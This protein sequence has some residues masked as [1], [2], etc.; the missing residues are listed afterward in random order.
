MSQ[1]TG[2]PTLKDIETKGKAVLVRVD[3]NVPTNSA[4]EVLDSTRIEAAKDTILELRGQGAKII[5]I[6]HMGRPGGEVQEKFSLKHVLSAVEEV[7]GQPVAF[8]EHTVGDKAEAAVNQ[9]NPGQILLLENL[10]FDP[11]EKSND[12]AFAQRLA[13]LADLYV[14][15][16]FSAAHRAHASTAAVTHYLPAYAGR[17]MERE[18]K[19][20]TDALEDPERPALALVGGAKVSTKLDLL[21][22]IV[23][24][25]DY[26]VLGGG[27]ANTFLEAKGHTIGQSLSE[28]DMVDTV[29]E[30]MEEAG[31]QGCE[32]ILPEIVM[33]AKELKDNAAAAD[34]PLAEVADDDKILDLGAAACSEIE[35]VI[36]QCQTVLWN[37]PLGVFEVPPFDRAT[38]RIARYVAREVQNGSLKAIAGGGDTVSAL[39]QTGVAGQM[40]YVSTAGGAFLEWL[41]GKDLPAIERLREIKRERDSSCPAA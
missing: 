16:A 33:V 19:A 5:L 4:G 31:T 9:L 2:L 10:R 36:A 22:N 1:N 7:L 27:M 15:D 17:L 24:K 40:S 38:T 39:N 8:C 18:V 30:I 6:S 3:F 20:L 35:S 29:Q 23:S 32:I 13:K 26:L 21:K 14:N 28:S 25:V 34:K 41:E 37:G 12:E 11:G